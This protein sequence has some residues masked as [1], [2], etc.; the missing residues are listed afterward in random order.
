MCSIVSDITRISTKKWIKEKKKNVKKHDVHDCCVCTA[1]G[2]MCTQ[3]WEVAWTRQIVQVLTLRW[4]E[5]EVRINAP[6]TSLY[7]F[8]SILMKYSQSMVFQN[9]KNLERYQNL[10]LQMSCFYFY[11]RQD[12][13]YTDKVN[14]YTYTEWSRCR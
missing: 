14:I 10:K 1:I 6:E 5:S 8:D 3:V 12:P 13:H 7:K 4:V 2:V 11:I 9:A